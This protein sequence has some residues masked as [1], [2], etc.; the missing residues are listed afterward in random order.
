MDSQLLRYQKKLRYI[1]T[2]SKNIKYQ[3]ILTK[4]TPERKYPSRQAVEFVEEAHAL[5]PEF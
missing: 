4:N 1:E 2:L 3:V 5:A